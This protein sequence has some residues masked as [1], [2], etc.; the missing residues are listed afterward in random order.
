MTFRK[1]VLLALC[2]FS[3]SFA[4]FSQAIPSDLTRAKIDNYTDEELLTWYQ[5]AIDNGLTENQLYTLAEQR[6]LPAAEIAKLKSRLPYII[7]S[8]PKSSTDN[9]NRNN[10]NL[11]AANERRYDTA[12]EQLPMQSF[13][14]D[15]QIFGSELF[16]KNSL[17]FEPNLRIA[18][19]EGYVLGP[20]DELLI[21][22]YGYSEKAFNLKVNQEGF[23]YIP[24]IGPVYVS[25]LTIEDATAKIRSKLSATIYRALRTGQTK[26][27]ITLGKI[28]SVRVTV[29]GEAKKPGTYTVSSLTTLYNLLYLCG[30]PTTMGSY[31]SI[32]L[33]RGNKLIRTVDL[34]AFIVKGDQKDNLMLREGDVIR[35]PY[36]KTR[37]QIK[38][39]VKRSG[40]FELLDNE[41]FNTLLEYSGGFNDN[42]YTAAV[43]VIRITNSQR[44]IIDLNADQFAGFRPKSS[45]EYTIG[46]LQQDFENKISISGSVIRPGNYELTPGLTVKQLIEKAGGLTVDAFTKRSSI[47]R[48][49]P[50][51]Q[52]AF[53]SVNL[54]S[55]LLYNQNIL[56]KKDDSLAVHS[57]FEFRDQSTVTIDGSVRKPGNFEWRE[58]L[59]LRDVLLAAGGLT[60]NGDSSSIEI[61]RRIRDAQVSK[62]NH[63]QTHVFYINLS[64]KNGNENEVLQPYDLILVKSLSGYSSQRT[65]L[66]TG[67][68][69]S[70]GRYSLQKS[71]ERISDIFKRVGFKASAD[72]A[73]VTIRRPNNSNMSAAERERLF[74][75]ILSVNEDSLSS[76]VRLKGELFKSYDMLSINLASAL[77]HPNSADNIILEDGDILNIDRTNNLVKISGEVF[78]PTKI[79]FI[80]GKNLKY[81]IKQSGNYTNK[82]R[83]SGVVIIYPDGKAKSVKSFLGIRSY[84]V[85]TQRSEIFVPEK[86]NTNRTKLGATEW[87]LIVSA[88]GIVANVIISS[89]K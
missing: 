86:S 79:P 87:A 67:E 53:L 75:R 65:V 81:Y 66:I 49:Q 43:S 29:I 88:L 35:I 41:T 63:I 42:A 57:I 3:F 77:K 38:G 6:G 21:N 73:S 48:L 10:N 9:T 64:N 60:D 12:N 1:I 74:Q 80:S 18:T 15:N 45:D 85:V 56:L 84:P 44:K 70:P 46:S 61:S 76:N 16:T 23:I 62:L 7:T 37:V 5:K 22:I 26:L 32:E 83:K 14:R 36:Y 59:T 4:G 11:P 17:V 72:T 54:D 39:N 40:K 34:Y 25:G 20:D 13:D 82:A 24:N 47:Y 55:V 27:Q 69:N 51:K 50:N 78:Y 52:L 31:R 2:L 68:V 30:G 28:R 71:N 33:I 58:N 19:P 8:I 89:K